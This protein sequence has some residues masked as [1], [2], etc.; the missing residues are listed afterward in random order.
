M[1]FSK[2]KF[3][4]SLAIEPLSSLSNISTSISSVSNDLS[5]LL[6]ERPTMSSVS[7][8]AIKVGVIFFEFETISSKI[9]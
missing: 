2:I 3:T 5:R 9:S 1:I 8:E 4:D 7:L 6:L